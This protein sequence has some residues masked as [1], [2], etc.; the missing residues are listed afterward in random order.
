MTLTQLTVIIRTADRKA[1]ADELKRLGYIYCNRHHKL[2]KVGIV[3]IIQ[4]VEQETEEFA[5]NARKHLF[6]GRICGIVKGYEKYEFVYVS[7]FDIKPSTDPFD[8]EETV[9]QT[10]MDI[11]AKEITK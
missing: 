6:N 5:D 3:P 1:I 11:F 9:T 8:D 10:A 7:I 4:A 2:G